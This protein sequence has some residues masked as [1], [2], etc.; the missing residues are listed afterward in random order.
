MIGL[1]LGFIAAVIGTIVGLA[2]GLIGTVA[3]LVGLLLHLSPALLAVV[4]IAML[5]KKSDAGVGVRPD[6][7]WVAMQYEP[8]MRAAEAARRRP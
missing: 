7:R 5:V 6:P 1:L 2:G 4:A 3:H 8:Q